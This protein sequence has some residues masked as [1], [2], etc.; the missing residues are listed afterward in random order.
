MI[1]N[2]FTNGCRRRMRALLVK[3]VFQIIKDPSSILI[4]MVLPII[5]LFLYGTGVSLDLDHLRV[6]VVLEDTS[7]DA[8]TFAK[9]FTDS[10]Y[11]DVTFKWDRRELLDDLERGVIRGM[12]IVPSY[13]SDFRKHQNKVAPIQVIADGSETNTANFV[14]NYAK[15]A[16]AKWAIQEQLNGQNVIPMPP[17]TIQ[18]RYWYN[19]QL[20]SS[21]F[22]V[23]GSLAITMTLIGTLLTSLVVAREWE[24]GTMEGLMSTP[25]GIIE[26]VLSKLI[27]YFLLGMISLFLSVSL[28]LL[29][30]HIPFR[31]SFW[32]L[33]LISSV[34]LFTALG[35]GLL[36]STYAKNQIV[37]SQASIIAGFMPSYMLSGFIFEITSMPLPIQWLT[38]LMPARYFVT[39]LQSIFLV[40]N[41][42]P[43]LIKNVIP[44]GIIGV[45]LFLLTARKTVKR[46]D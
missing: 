7:P 29:I 34:F 38:Y 5:F 9:S 39:C 26:F 2:L 46:L 4:S 43:L 36:I 31:G 24:R 16:F 22:L 8:Q 35:T 20:E 6:G 32:V 17:L 23:T 44:M 33:C 12:V 40:G 45:I 19:E 10:S 1:A 11:F 18:T 41:V 28:A 13:F 37:A 27:A 14:Q 30:Y 25:M 15:G 42:W 21:Y 3:E